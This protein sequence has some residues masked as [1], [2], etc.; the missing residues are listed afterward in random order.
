MAWAAPQGFPYI[1]NQTAY[2]VYHQSSVSEVTV[3]GDFNGWSPT[4]THLY[5]LA[6]TNFYYRG[7]NFENDAR[8]DYKFVVDGNWILDPLNPHTITGG[9]G[10]NSELA[11]PGYV[12]PPEIQTY[13]IPHGALET[14]TFTDDLQGRSRQVWVY[15]PPE[16]DSTHVYPTVYFHDGGE[17]LSLAYARNVLDYLIDQQLIE[18]VV[19]IFVDPT[20][21]NEEYT[22]DNA[23]L[24]MFVQDLVPYIDS[25][26]AT[27]QDSSHRAV[28]GVSLGGLT[29]LW[30]AYEHPEIFGCAAG[31]SPS[32][33]LGNLL[34][35]YT[36]AEPNTRL[37]LDAGT[38]EGQL[39]QS[40]VQLHNILDGKNWPHR[41]RVWHEGHSWGSW[42]AHLDEALTYFFPFTTTAIDEGSR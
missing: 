10:P 21:R 1:E 36:E 25:H 16:Y 18:P 12:Q 11:M 27:S 8:L 24:T 34:Q 35:D 30:F 31:F 33:W 2:F 17:Y 22:Y 28:V 38:Y 41:W 3:A 32:V 6:G 4:V 9:F 23:F 5:R 19:A 14:F 37:Y 7:L 15:L 40:T 39:Y 29:A 13:P 26:Y 20:N 42:R